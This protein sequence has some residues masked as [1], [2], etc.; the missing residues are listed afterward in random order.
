MIHSDL[1]EGYDVSKEPVP[2][3]VWYRP[4]GMGSLSGST[5]LAV[6]L[7]D[8]KRAGRVL[9]KHPDKCDHGTTICGGKHEDGKPCVESW[10]YDFSILWSRTAG[11]RK[12]L[13][14]LGITADKH[15]NPEHPANKF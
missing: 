4:D 3:R 9:I 10:Q 2:P 13:T 5:Y 11:G 1:P 12:L 6:L 14:E 8:E 7:G 15:Q